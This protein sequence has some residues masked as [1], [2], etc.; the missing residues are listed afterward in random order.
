MRAD[1]FKGTL[2]TLP[3]SSTPDLTLYEQ[4]GGGVSRK[5]EDAYPTGGPVYGPSFSGVRFAHFF[6]RFFGYFMFFVVCVTVFLVWSLSQ[7]ALF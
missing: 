1:L 2:F 6:V 3:L 5:A 4:L 7:T